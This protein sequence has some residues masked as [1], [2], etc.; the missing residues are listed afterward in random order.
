VLAVNQI[1]ST[2]SYNKGR[3]DKAGD[4][5]VIEAILRL[6]S[7][8]PYQ[9]AVERMRVSGALYVWGWPMLKVLLR[10]REYRH[11]LTP[12]FVRKNLWHT[13]KVALKRMGP[14]WLVNFYCKL[15]GYRAKPAETK[16]A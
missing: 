2:T 5:K 3:R 1:D 9:D 10:H 13:A 6:L 11:Y 14:A 8:S 4:L 7:E 15:A 12:T 16:T